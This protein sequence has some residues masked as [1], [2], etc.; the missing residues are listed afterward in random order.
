MSDKIYNGKIKSIETSKVIARK[1]KRR[2]LL[3]IIGIGD[4]FINWNKTPKGVEFPKG[5]D[6]QVTMF[7]HD[8]LRWFV[9]EI[10]SINGKPIKSQNSYKSAKNQRKNRSRADGKK[11]TDTQGI[12]EQ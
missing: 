1:G 10:I 12:K 3:S 4:A 5:A 6:I 9:K 11:E 2:I 7:R 8:D